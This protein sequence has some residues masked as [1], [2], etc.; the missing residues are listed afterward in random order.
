MVLHKQFAEVTVN[1][2]ESPWNAAT[3]EIAVKGGIN[4]VSLTD[5]K[6]VEGR[7]YYE[8]PK[9]P[10]GVRTFRLPRQTRESAAECARVAEDYRLGRSAAGERT[11]GLYYRELL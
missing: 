3:C 10:R 6:P 8:V 9:D 4:G 11:G 5:L 1:L 2:D 7:F